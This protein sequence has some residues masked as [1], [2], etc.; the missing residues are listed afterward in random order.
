MIEGYLT[1]KQVAENG[2]LLGEEFRRCALREGYLG[3]QDSDMSGQYLP[4]LKDRLM[5]E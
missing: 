2:V 1:I 3:Q 5:A 4:M